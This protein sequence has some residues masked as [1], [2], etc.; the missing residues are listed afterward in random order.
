VA[1]DR[2]MEDLGREKREGGPSKWQAQVVRYENDPRLW[3][4]LVFRVSFIL[5]I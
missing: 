3:L 2:S 1:Q 4:W 5:S